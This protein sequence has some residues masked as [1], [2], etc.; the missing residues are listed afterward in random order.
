[1]MNM[2]T[3]KGNH[4]IESAF[5]NFIEVVEQETGL[6]IQDVDCWI[7]RAEQDEVETALKVEG[8]YKRSDCIKVVDDHKVWGLAD[9]SI[10]VHP[11]DTSILQEEEE[12]EE[13]E[14]KYFRTCHICLEEF[15]ADEQDNRFDEPTDKE[16][17]ERQMEE[18]E[19]ENQ[20]QQSDYR[21]SVL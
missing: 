13:E 12:E 16:C 19:Q 7:H 6:K 18:W 5:A 1:M 8:A 10:C 21:N 2:S 4:N 20:Q 17:A 11:L 9:V 3:F 15:P 14:N